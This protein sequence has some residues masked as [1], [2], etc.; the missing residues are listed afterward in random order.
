[1][2][3]R[4]NASAVSV[5][6]YPRIDLWQRGRGIKNME[7]IMPDWLV[8]LLN[9][10]AV[11]TALLALVNVLIKYFAPNMPAEILLA[12]NALWI[13]VL[14]ALGIVVSNRMRARGL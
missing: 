1:M 4:A 3:N 6:P 7:V 10:G 5:R 11:W 2:Y 8:K 14:A 13:A 9:S 12:I